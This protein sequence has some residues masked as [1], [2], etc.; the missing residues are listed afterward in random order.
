[1][2]V[3]LKDGVSASQ[4]LDE[5]NAIEAAISAT[6]DE[7]VELRG[8]IVPLQS[9]IAGKSRQG[10]L[11]LLAAVAAVLLIV[12]VNIANLLLARATGRGREFAIR[13]AIGANSAQL[14]RQLLVESVL[15]S[16]VGGALGLVLADWA[17]RVILAN[18]PVDLPRLNEISLDGRI[19]GMTFVL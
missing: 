8:L 10:L 12:C 5:L 14:I 1:G 18:A 4:A 3:R 11:V 17:L 16:T 2:I 19:L 15:L 7:K 6:L 9:Q 13:R